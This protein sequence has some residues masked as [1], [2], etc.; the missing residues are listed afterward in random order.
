MESTRRGAATIKIQ[1]ISAGTEWAI[2]LGERGLISDNFSMST[3][4]NVQPDS[5][6]TETKPKG[7]Q[8]EFILHL[9]IVYS[10]AILKF[11]NGSLNSIVVEKLIPE[12]LTQQLIFRF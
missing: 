8:V 1:N 7:T 10:T 3:I 5:R 2:V 4:E 12:S 11:L 6:E 9:G